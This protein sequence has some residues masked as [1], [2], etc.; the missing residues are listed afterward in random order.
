MCKEQV[1]WRGDR[2][3][4]DNHMVFPHPRPPESG[5]CHNCGT[6]LLIVDQIRLCAHEGC[7]TE[8]CPHCADKGEAF[9]CERCCKRCCEKHMRVIDDEQYCP[10]CEA[11]TLREALESAR[12][13]AEWQRKLYQSLCWRLIASVLGNVALACG[14]VAALSALVKA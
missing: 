5:D 9:V 14:L 2:L 10:D 12:E 11:I 3:M 8:I 4:L 13:D 7:W 6:A 1:S